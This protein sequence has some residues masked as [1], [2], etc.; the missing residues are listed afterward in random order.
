M[1]SQ[2][3]LASQIE[4]EGMPIW[5]GLSATVLRMSN[6]FDQLIVGGGGVTTY[7]FPS[8]IT[9]GTNTIANF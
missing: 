3:V 5:G 8:S 9:A 1:I 7:I 2:S 4:E 6:S